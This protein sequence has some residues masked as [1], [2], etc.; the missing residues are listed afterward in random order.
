MVKLISQQADSSKSISD[1][2]KLEGMLHSML[3]SPCNFTPLLHFI[4]PVQYD[5]MRAF[6]E[7]WI[8]PESDEKDMPDEVSSGMHILMVIDVDSIGRYEAEFFVY[9]KTIDFLLF[10]PKGYEAGYDELMRSMQKIL[11]GTEYRIGKTQ[12]AELEKTRSLMDVFKSLPYRRV[13]VDVKV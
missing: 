7:I 4:L 9:N 12:V 10:C 13:G 6:A 2:A 3:S 8:N 11:Y 5:E 1:S